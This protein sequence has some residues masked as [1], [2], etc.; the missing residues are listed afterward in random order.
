M[1]GEMVEREVLKL[2]VWTLLG[3]RVSWSRGG[4]WPLCSQEACGFWE[5]GRGVG[6]P[7][8]ETQAAGGNT[9]LEW[10]QWWGESRT[11]LGSV[12]FLRSL[13]TKGLEV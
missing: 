9:G 11:P 4:S 6:N 13:G 3:P 7:F 1:G 5:V 12:S 2:D 8:L 10:G